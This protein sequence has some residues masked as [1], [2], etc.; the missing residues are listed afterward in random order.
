MDN[1]STKKFVFILGRERELCLAELRAVLKRFCFDFSV[2]SVTENVA[3]INID[4][5]REDVAKMADILG[6]TVKIYEIIGNPPDIKSAIT[7][8]I[9]ENYSSAG[10]VTFGISAYPAKN[11]NITAR[12]LNQLG[13]QTKKNLKSFDLSSRFIELREST[14]VPTILSLKEKL[15]GKGVEFGI[16]PNAFGVLI[17]LSNPEEWNIRDYEKPAGDKYSGMLPPKLARMM[18]NIALEQSYKIANIKYQI[19][20]RLEINNCKA[21]V[22]DPFCG[23]GNILLEAL[24]LGCN[25]F[26][27]DTSEKAVRDSKTNID[28]LLKRYPLSSIRSE[29]LQADATNEDFLNILSTFHSLPSTNQLAV[30]T[31]PYLGE[32]KKFKPT[33]NAA[34]GEYQKVKEIYLQFFQNFLALKTLKLP[35]VF[36]VVFPLVETIEGRR[37]SLYRECVDEIKKIG[38]TELQS[39]LIYGRDYQVVKREISLLTLRE[40]GSL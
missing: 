30:I 26:G 16:F 5:E 33:M 20:K 28:W 21:I 13:F 39:P 15:V 27:S 17:G 1:T 14:D 32:P 6:G 7:N 37:L 4:K 31:E 19:S 36:C 35:V 10:K 18:V 34:K 23:S 40:K 29:V 24:M 22:V 8:F 25:V 3:F 11:L 9:K 2:L 12:A 38:Y